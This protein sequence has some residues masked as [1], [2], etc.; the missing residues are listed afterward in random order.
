MIIAVYIVLLFLGIVFISSYFKLVRDLRLLFI[1]PIWESYPGTILESNGE[2]IMEEVPNMPVAP[3]RKFSTSIKVAYQVNEQTFETYFN[4]RVFMYKSVSETKTTFKIYFPVGKIIPVYINGK[5]RSEIEIDG[6]K[7][8]R[9]KTGL[10][11]N[12]LFNI[13]RISMGIAMI[14]VGIFGIYSQLK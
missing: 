7:I 1:R 12:T 11:F 13:I 14:G 4:D 2:M 10:V 9:N 5:D 8:K 3:V 6:K